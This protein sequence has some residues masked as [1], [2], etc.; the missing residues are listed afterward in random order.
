LST[1]QQVPVSVSASLSAQGQNTVSI[2]GI[3]GLTSGSAT[4][5]STGWTFEAFYKPSSNYNQTLYTGETALPDATI[6]G[7]TGGKATIVLAPTFV[8]TDMPF[9]SSQYS[10]YGSQDAGTT[11][12]LLASGTLTMSQV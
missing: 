9:Q 2:S 1:A 11:W 3:T 5:L 10:L 12:V 6:T 8:S 7:I 4:N